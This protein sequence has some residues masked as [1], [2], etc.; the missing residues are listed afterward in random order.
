M[1]SFLKKNVKILLQRTGIYIQ[2]FPT[3]RHIYDFLKDKPLQIREYELR[4]ITAT[5]RVADNH[6]Q[7]EKLLK[8]FIPGWQIEIKKAQFV[9]KGIGDSSLNTY[10]K[11]LVGDKRYFEKVYFNA[12]QHLQTVRWFEKHIYD[13]IKDEI[14]V[15]LIQK[16]FH[17][18]LITTVYYDYFDLINVREETIEH[19]LIWFSKVLYDISCRYSST[20][21]KLAPPDSIRNFRNHP[22]YRNYK[23]MYSAHARLLKQGIDLKSIEQGID[24]SKC[25]LTHGDIN[26][27][28]AFENAILIDW[29]SFGI[30]PIGLDPAFIYY[31]LAIDKSKRTNSLAWLKKH[32]CNIITERDWR[33]FERNFTYFFYIFSLNRFD[34]GKFGHLEQ[35][36][37]KNLKEYF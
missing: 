37:I 34:Q 8:A 6:K 2:Y 11:V 13:M 7:Y 22:A 25:I 27:K 19:H 33:E 20:L 35:Q 36:L 28:N 18:E 26:K 9:G 15:P 16:S 24:Q 14:T 31:C 12:H 1:K 5:L 29:D 17:G 3:S 4:R 21:K 32:Y 30:F 23:K 10:R